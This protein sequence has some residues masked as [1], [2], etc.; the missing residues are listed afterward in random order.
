M[1]SKVPDAP[2][3]P[4]KEGGDGVDSGQSQ[5]MDLDANIDGAKS[6]A[7][8]TEGGD[9]AGNG[10]GNPVVA[11]DGAESKKRKEDEPDDSSAPS[12]K[13]AKEAPLP[14]NA[15]QQLADM[16]ANQQM[17]NLQGMA[18][19]HL[20]QMQ[21][22]QFINLQ[23]MAYAQQ[24]M[25]M[26]TLNAIN[27]LNWGSQLPPGLGAPQRMVT[28]MQRMVAS[29][30]GNVHHVVLTL[31]PPKT[32]LGMILDDNQTYNLPQLMGLTPA[33][34]MLH[35]LPLSKDCCIA[36]LKGGG[37][38]HAQPKTAAACA[39]LISKAQ[40]GKPQPAKLEVV[41]IET[42]RSSNAFLGF[43]ADGEPPH[44]KRAGGKPG[45]KPRAEQIE[46]DVLKRQALLEYFSDPAISNTYAYCQEIGKENFRST[47]ERL[48]K[49]DSKLAKLE[50]QRH[51]PARRK[52]AYAI[53]EKMFPP[54][55]AEDAKDRLEEARRL[56]RFLL[57]FFGG[58]ASLDAFCNAK[59]I[60]AADRRAI[61]RFLDREGKLAKLVDRRLDPNRREEAIDIIKKAFEDSDSNDEEEQLENDSDQKQE[62]KSTTSSAKQAVLPERN[63]FFS[64]E[65]L[66]LIAE[67]L[68]FK[69]RPRMSRDGSKEIALNDRKV[70]DEHLT[71]L[72]IDLCNRVLKGRSLSSK[73]RSTTMTNC[74]RVLFYDHGYKEATKMSG[75][76][77]SNKWEQRLEDAYM[78]GAD[79]HPLA[80]LAMGK[81][82]YTDKIEQDHPGL[83]A[84][85]HAQAEEVLG[86]DAGAA[87][88]AMLMNEISME[89]AC[90]DPLFPVLD[91]NKQ[92]LR[93]WELAQ[94]IQEQPGGGK[95]GSAQPKTE[96]RSI[97]QIE[98]K[99]PDL[100]E[101]LYHFA[102]DALG[103][104][105][106]YHLLATC[107]NER[108]K[109]AVEADPNLPLVTMSKQTL[110]AWLKKQEL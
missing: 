37:V 76:I 90:D 3:A 59:K 81:D 6:E 88:K 82:S 104:D 60:G 58:T 87:E 47:M 16:L 80:K 52:E 84:R 14:T 109:E 46:F 89:E 38:G 110:P 57:G 95:N 43:K 53:I 64:P 41:L 103:P 9:A 15:Q 25:N 8:P 27:A 56:R 67:S 85:L 94:K 86:S 61:M 73:G 17:M 68:D 12:A 7:S 75:L 30:G 42:K 83:L 2:P 34:P 93:K 1:P 10:G 79:Q 4:A 28:V 74:V 13:K 24:M 108:A 92:T 63:N 48:I 11:D 35:Q 55:A 32:K 23:Q 33:S 66:S 5:A 21:L 62:G 91:M 39:K 70:P 98:K 49:K 101:G 22:Q 97:C 31:P 107:M 29:T 99:H 51:V 18:P 36:L 40:K 65:N 50:G 20:Q 105:A 77:N 69:A 96:E 44:K 106:S 78:S 100:I 72:M 19:M 54:N 26:N 45:R 71:L 102:L